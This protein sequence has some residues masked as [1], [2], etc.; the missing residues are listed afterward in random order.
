MSLFV[1]LMSGTSIDAIDAVLVSFVEPKK[2][3]VQAVHSHP[4]PPAMRETLLTLSQQNRERSL[5]DEVARLD[6]ETGEL[7][8]QATL[9]LLEQAQVSAEQ[10]TAIGSPGQTLYHHPQG[11]IPYTWQ[12]GDPNVITQLT[13]IPTV[14][15]FRRRDIAAGGQGAPLAPAFHHAFLRSNEEK[16]VVLNLGG[17]A[18]ITLLPSD[19]TEPVIGFDTGPG[20]GLLD[21]FAAQQLHSH[22]DQGGQWAASGK[23]QPSL[24]KAFLADPYFSRPAPKTTGRDYF[25]LEWITRHILGLSLAPQ[26]VQATL[27]QLTVDSINQAILPYAPQRLLVGGGG[28]HNNFLIKQ[29]TDTLACEVESTQAYGIDPDWVEATCFAWLA[30]QR[31]E[32]ISN[33]LP[34]VTGARTAVVL[35]SVYI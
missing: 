18:N 25:N 26:D 4:W 16:R 33:N 7:F 34:S 8:A 12:L 32:N 11:P 29:L 6:I 1:G 14:A 31:L 30:K 24:L 28:V 20:N 13:G 3:A 22:F 5:I 19:E 15:D 21:A 2:L 10:I 35:G 27:C 9:A 17:I 23:V